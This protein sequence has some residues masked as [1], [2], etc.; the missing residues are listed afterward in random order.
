ME[1]LSSTDIKCQWSKLRQ[2]TLTKYKPLP[3]DTFDCCY[4][5]TKKINIDIDAETVRLAYYLL[6][7]YNLIHFQSSILKVEVYL[8]WTNLCNSRQYHTYGRHLPG[9]SFISNQ[10]ETVQIIDLMLSSH[11]L[12]DILQNYPVMD[13]GDCCKKF[14]YSK[15][16]TDVDRILNR[17]FSKRKNFLGIKQT[18]SNNRKSVLWVVHI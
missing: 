9:N 8:L 17:F 12:M 1:S 11:P 4:K 7:N 5:K 15:L 3:V 14:Y 16:S 6:I 13:M 10:N 2:P 18:I